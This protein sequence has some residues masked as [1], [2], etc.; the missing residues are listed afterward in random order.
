MPFYQ[1]GNVACQQKA[2]C[3]ISESLKRQ[4]HLNLTQFKS[5]HKFTYKVIVNINIQV[6]SS[7]FALAAVENAQSEILS[8]ILMAKSHQ[9][10]VLAFLKKVIVILK[11]LVVFP[12]QGIA[13]VRA[14]LAFQVDDHESK[15]MNHLDPVKAEEWS[16]LATSLIKALGKVSWCIYQGK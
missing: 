15:P 6:L 10:F 8:F 4:L 11:M 3:Y 7:V 13:T 14:N 5:L 16:F 1:W 2:L 12:D 9:D